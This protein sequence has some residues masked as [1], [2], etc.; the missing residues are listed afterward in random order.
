MSKSI[1]FRGSG[2]WP[3]IWAG[4]S[5]SILGDEIFTTSVTLWVGSVLA[6]GQSWGPIAVAAVLMSSQVPVILVSLAAGGIVDRGNQR[7]IIITSAFASALTCLA[8]LCALG[9]AGGLTAAHLL[10]ITCCTVAGLSVAGQFSR[11]ANVRLIYEA[12]PV[13]KRITALGKMLTTAQALWIVGPALA[14]PVFFTLGIQGTVTLN[15]ISFAIAGVIA[16]RLSQRFERAGHAAPTEHRSLYEDIREALQFIQQEKV[17]SVTLR[18][19]FVLCTGA[20]STNAVSYFFITEKM[21]VGP[22]FLGIF[23]SLIAIGAIV[24]SYLARLFV[25]EDGFPAAYAGSLIFFSVLVFLYA[26]SSDA[27]SGGLLYFLW[28]VSWGVNSFSFQS[29]LTSTVPKHLIGRISSCVAPVQA[30]SAV[31]GFVIGGYL[32]RQGMKG[33]EFSLFSLHLDPMRAAY[34]LL[35]LLAAASGAYSIWKFHEIGRIDI[36]QSADLEYGEVVAHMVEPEEPPSPT[37][38]IPLR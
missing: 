12:V 23:A 5:V 21:H 9:I 17:L 2:N 24:G 14:V 35:S 28:G 27:L 1:R 10:I 16:M 18:T 33:V 29:L 6:V 32:A 11:P 31:L 13:D 8:L 37:I 34:Y 3:K 26:N 30:I 38:R 19:F 25:K 36:V 22:A 4:E 20:A 7:R 15:L